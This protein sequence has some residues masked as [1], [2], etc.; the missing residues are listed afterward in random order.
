MQQ[1]ADVP[2]LLGSMR[3]FKKRAEEYFEEIQKLRLE[4]EVRI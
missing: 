1:E 3:F 2:T 4:V